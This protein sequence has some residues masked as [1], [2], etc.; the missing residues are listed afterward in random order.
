MRGSFINW[1]CAGPA[2]IYLSVAMGIVAGAITLAHRAHHIGSTT[3]T[4]LSILPDDALTRE[5]VRCQ[6]LGRRAEDDAG[7][8]AAW[9]ENRR[10]FFN[11]PDR[12]SHP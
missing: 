1:G 9:A 2:L 6:S 7:C 12:G 5:L 11:S 3:P 4:G 8:I 10:R